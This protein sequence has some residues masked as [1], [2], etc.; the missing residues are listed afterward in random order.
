MHAPLL[1]IVIA[2]K[3]DEK[4]IERCLESIFHQ[5]IQDYEIIIVNDSSSDGTLDIVKRFAKNNIRIISRDNFFTYPKYKSNVMRFLV[6]N[7]NIRFNRHTSKLPMFD[8]VL[9]KTVI[10]YKN[11][12]IPDD[13]E[14][15]R[16]GSSKLRGKYVVYIGANVY[17][18]NTFIEKCV[19]PLEQ[20]KQCDMCISCSRFTGNYKI[21]ESKMMYSENRIIDEKEGIGNFIQSSHLNG[22][23][24]VF[25]N[26]K[27]SY[28]SKNYSGIE[29]KLN[30]PYRMLFE[31]S[32]FICERLISVD[33][34][35]IQYEE[36]VNSV[37]ISRRFSEMSTKIWELTVNKTRD[38]DVPFLLEVY[39]E[40]FSSLSSM[41]LDIAKWLLDREMLR[42]AKSH[43]YFAKMIDIDVVLPRELLGISIEQPMFT[44]N[45]SG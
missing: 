19:N 13:D 15:F 28:L 35:K 12:D 36:Y 24:C 6:K 8:D 9:I 20:D 16:I 22:V 43:L 25:R 26:K 17:F 31:K 44:K 21:I 7:Q 14:C 18:D 32:I 23:I 27:A 5:T 37:V 4:Y 42:E 39:K 34:R 40:S 10:P 41:A 3:N 30:V 2:I 29:F 38:Y 11:I 45:G 33:L 1:S